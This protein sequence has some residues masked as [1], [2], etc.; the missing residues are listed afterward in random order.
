MTFSE[1]QKTFSPTPN[2]LYKLSDIQKDGY[3]LG[4][5]L[6]DK[7]LAPILEGLDQCKFPSYLVYLCGYDYI[8]K[9]RAINLTKAVENSFDKPEEFG[10]ASDNLKT[11]L[12]HYKG[13]L[14]MNPKLLKRTAKNNF[15]MYQLVQKLDPKAGYLFLGLEKASGLIDRALEI[16]LPMYVTT[17]RKSKVEKFEIR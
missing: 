10:D 9:A 17:E 4:E 13:V 3:A 16:S 8:G 5:L 14:I 7:R 15:L 6:K 2:G 11:Q 1:K 12:K